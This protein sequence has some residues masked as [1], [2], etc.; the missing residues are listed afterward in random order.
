MRFFI[1]L[2]V[3][4]LLFYWISAD[5]VLVGRN[6]ISNSSFEN[7]PGG[8][9]EDP[10]GWGSWNSD[11]NGIA[12]DEF[13]SGSQAA[14]IMCPKTDDSDGIFF[15]YAK[16]K[17]GK[18]Y[19]FSCY[20]K[21]SLKDPMKGDV[22]GQISIEWYKKGRDKD[23]KDI[24]IEIDRDWGPKFGPELPVI[25][26]VPFT[27]SATAPA[28]SDTCRF[29]IQFFN[30]GT[31][32]G[33][34]FA[35]EASAE[36]LS[37][38]F[39]TKS[40]TTQAGRKVAGK[41]LLPNAGF[42]KSSGTAGS[43]PSEWI[44]WNVDYNGVANEKAKTGSQSIY[45]SSPKQSETHDGVYYHYNDVKPGKEYLFSCYVINSFKDPLSGDAYGQL[46]I[47]WQ[48][49]SKDKDGKDITIEIVRSWGPAFD[50]SLSTSE[51]KLQSMTAAAPADAESCNFV[52]QLF[53]KEGKGTFYADDAIAEEK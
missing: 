49:K 25:K 47:E 21:N 36:E 27:M 30:K 29:V 52:I 14:Y 13:R 31:G 4:V 32:S 35:E 41:N 6:I 15:T 51:W 16:V 24:L 28:N 37:K 34:F 18:E 2:I 33:M 50:A 20:V 1:V 5:A 40:K 26:W 17:P 43:D 10:R 48:K 22:F 42:E 7:R 44:C 53:N 39:K 8:K 9:D 46:S 19:T 38:Y 23:G 11:L 12:T 3:G 45:V